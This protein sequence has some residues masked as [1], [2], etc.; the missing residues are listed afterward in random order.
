MRT[1]NE[2]GISLP[3][4]CPELEQF[5]TA[6]A[7]IRAAARIAD[8][9]T[10]VKPQQLSKEQ[11]DKFRDLATEIYDTLWEIDSD[12]QDLMSAF[13]LPLYP[14]SNPLNPSDHA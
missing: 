5:I 4:N 3:Q 10:I 2:A 1:Q 9:F 13:Y 14:V 12:V 6:Q 8:D 11:Q 7:H